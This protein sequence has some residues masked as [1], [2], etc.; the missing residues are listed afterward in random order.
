MDKIVVT[1]PVAPIWWTELWR[2]WSTCQ[3]ASEAMEC[4]KA[5]TRPGVFQ[6]SLPQ[7]YKKLWTTSESQYYWYPLA[8]SSC[9]IG[10][11]SSI[12]FPMHWAVWF[13]SSDPLS[14]YQFKDE[15]Y[16]KQWWYCSVELTTWNNM[17]LQLLVERSAKLIKLTYCAGNKKP[18]HREK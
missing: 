12:S 7:Q 9:I 11:H 8:V 18:T 15:F 17:R 13:C 2:G 10:S 14:R 3:L 5:L 1:V 6:H 4:E 16:R